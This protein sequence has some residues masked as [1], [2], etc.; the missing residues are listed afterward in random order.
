MHPVTGFQVC[1][2]HSMLLWVAIFSPLIN[3]VHIYSIN[4]QVVFIVSAV[5]F[6]GLGKSEFRWA[7]YVLNSLAAGCCRCVALCNLRKNLVYIVKIAHPCA[8]E[9]PA[10]SLHGGSYAPLASCPEVTTLGQRGGSGVS[11]QGPGDTQWG[12]GEQKSRLPDF[13]FPRSPGPASRC[14]HPPTPAAEVSPTS[15]EKSDGHS[16]YNLLKFMKIGGPSRT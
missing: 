8:P 11:S 16:T 9:C 12:V 4:L 15:P 2:V 5:N 1:S 13:H 3:T 10:G 6:D 7:S 14:I